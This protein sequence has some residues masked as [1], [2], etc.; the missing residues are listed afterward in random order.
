MD[1]TARSSVKP[2]SSTSF[3]RISLAWSNVQLAMVYVVIERTNRTFQ[4]C[5]DHV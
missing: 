5:I 3:H 4:S 1:G 2:G